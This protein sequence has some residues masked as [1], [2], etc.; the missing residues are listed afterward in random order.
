MV[1]GVTGAT[2]TDEL[3]NLEVKDVKEESGFM[4]VKIRNTKN[5]MP[6]SF[7]VVNGDEYNDRFLDILKKYITIRNNNARESQ[8]RFFFKYAKGKCINQPVGKNT[9]SHIPSVIAKFLD[10]S[11]PESYTGH[12]F[13]RTSA[14]LLANT[15]ADIL[16]LKRHGGWKSSAIAEG[17]VAE[18]IQNKLE[19]AKKLVSSTS[20]SSTA[21]ASNFEKLSDSGHISSVS[22]CINDG[23]FLYKEISVTSVNNSSDTCNRNNVPVINIS[24]CSNCK[25]TINVNK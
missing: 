7:T 20:S 3:V 6:R 5:K 22:D 15:G 9:F 17:Y 24:N 12:S 2:R 10:L 21:I 13:R 19:V 25:F 4:L 18:S 11:S 16:K 8:T 1:I 23:E 14:T